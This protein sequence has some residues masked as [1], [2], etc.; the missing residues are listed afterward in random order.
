MSLMPKF[1]FRLAP[2]LISWHAYE[3][4]FAEH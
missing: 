3:W 1:T 4:D 2:H